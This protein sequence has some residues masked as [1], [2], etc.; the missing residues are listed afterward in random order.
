MKQSDGLKG[1]C[2]SQG[3]SEERTKPSVPR[4][5]LLKLEPNTQLVA[6][7]IKEQELL[8]HKMD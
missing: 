1:N 6:P 8:E 4:T 5:N 2:K 3:L 7:M